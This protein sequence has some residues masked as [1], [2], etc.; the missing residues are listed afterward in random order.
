MTCLD[1]DA[2]L[3]AILLSTLS[4]FVWLSFGLGM[5]EIL[6]DLPLSKLVTVTSDFLR[7]KGDSRWEVVGLDVT[8]NLGLANSWLALEPLDLAKFEVDPIGE[9]PGDARRLRKSEV[10]ERGVDGADEYLR[11][12]VPLLDAAALSLDS[13]APP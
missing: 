1:F 13:T 2:F 6:R 3:V 8:T 12:E 10:L 4:K 5:G 7:F 11:P 9:R